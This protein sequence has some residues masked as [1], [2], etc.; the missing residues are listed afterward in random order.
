[1]GRGF[2]PGLNWG[3]W[4]GEVLGN[5]PNF[6]MFPY[7]SPNSFCP[8]GIKPNNL[9]FCQQKLVQNHFE[10]ELV[11]AKPFCPEPKL[12]FSDQNLGFCSDFERFRILVLVLSSKCLAQS[13]WFKVFGSNY[14][15]ASSRRLSRALL[16]GSSQSSSL[17]G[18][19]QCIFFSASFFFSSKV[20]LASSSSACA[21]CCLSV[22]RRRPS[23]VSRGQIPPLPT[24]SRICS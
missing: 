12:V 2:L 21:C 9:L 4:D 7:T 23:A 11:T 16:L 20:S 24:S 19:A 8:N 13:V 6:P 18:P 5:P 3:N 14:A 22:F 15:Y 10:S 17:L 1:M